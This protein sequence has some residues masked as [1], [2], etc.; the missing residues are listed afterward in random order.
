M[1]W[2]YNIEVGWIL[3]KLLGQYLLWAVGWKCDDVIIYVC[4]Y[5]I[6]PRERHV[7]A[8][9]APHGC[10]VSDTFLKHHRH[11][12]CHIIATSSATSSLQVMWQVNPWRSL[13]SQIL[14]FGLGS[15]GFTPIYDG[16]RTSWIMLIYDENLRTSREGICDAQ[17]MTFSNFVIDVILW[18][19]FDDPW[20]NLTVIDHEIFCSDPWISK[21]AACI[22]TRFWGDVKRP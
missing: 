5:W 12:I 13:S 16:L 8:T 21:M 9:S 22:E 1:G 17:Y 2:N 10:H 15:M 7:T 14:G 4:W 20:R 3:L 11:V 18:R 19:N 6:W